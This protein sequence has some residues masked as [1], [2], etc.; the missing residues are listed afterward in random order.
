MPRRN[1]PEQRAARK[2]SKRIY[3]KAYYVTHKEHIIKIVTTISQRKQHLWQL[4]QS[5]LIRVVQDKNDLPNYTYEL[6][7]EFEKKEYAEI[8]F[9]D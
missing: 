1:T 7:T 6:P 4:F 8:E 3:L 2:E 9:I 5:G